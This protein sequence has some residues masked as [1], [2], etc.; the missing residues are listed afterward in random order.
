[1]GSIVTDRTSGYAGAFGG[2]TRRP[3]NQI[4]IAPAPRSKRHAERVAQL[5][6]EVE[7]R[8]PGLGWWGSKPRPPG[9]TKQVDLQ[10]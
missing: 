3:P 1:M 4:E 8:G 9:T 5:I 2:L 6:E 10:Q 7:R